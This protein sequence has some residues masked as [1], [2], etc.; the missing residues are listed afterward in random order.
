MSCL[1]KFVKYPRAP[2][3]LDKCGITAALRLLRNMLLI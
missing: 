3:A 1:T 2:R